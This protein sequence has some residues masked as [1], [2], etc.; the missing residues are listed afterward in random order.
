V[1]TSSSFRHCGRSRGCQPTFP[2]FGHP[3][4]IAS[5]AGQVDHRPVPGRSRD[6]D[7]NVRGVGGGRGL[8]F[9]DPEEAPLVHRRPHVSLQ[10]FDIEESL[11]GCL[12]EHHEGLVGAG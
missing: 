11:F 3:K 7:S 10:F 9:H 12:L 5:T 8:G 1:L 6:D 4:P 2:L